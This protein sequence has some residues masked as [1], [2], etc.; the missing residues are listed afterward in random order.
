MQKDTIVEILANLQCQKTRKTQKPLF[1]K[2]ET[3]KNIFLR[4]I[5]FEFSFGKKDS[6]CRENAF[7]KRKTFLT[8]KRVQFDKIDFFREFFLF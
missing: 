8:V 6:Y 5:F 1:P 2:L 3:S 7:L 4:N